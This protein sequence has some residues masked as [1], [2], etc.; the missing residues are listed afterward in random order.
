MIRYLGQRLVESAILLVVV[1]TI[2]FALIHSAPGLPSIAASLEQSQAD[3]DRF[4]KSY[5][6]AAPIARTVMQTALGIS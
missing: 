4:V 3:R 5:R 6:T 1:S 2:T